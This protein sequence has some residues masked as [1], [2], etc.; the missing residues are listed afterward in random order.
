MSLD[1]MHDLCPLPPLRTRL[2][3]CLAAIHSDANRAR[4]EASIFILRLGTLLEAMTS[5]MQE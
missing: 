2:A 3:A 5:A 4:D 1:C